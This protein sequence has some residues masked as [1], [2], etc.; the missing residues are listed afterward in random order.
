MLNGK[1]TRMALLKMLYYASIEFE[2]DST[3]KFLTPFAL[4]GR[5]EFKIEIEIESGGRESP[6]GCSSSGTS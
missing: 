5:Q 4:S 3:E 2:P 6:N 1:S